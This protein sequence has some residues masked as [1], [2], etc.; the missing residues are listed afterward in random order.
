VLRRGA[1]SAGG[2]RR[3]V[4]RFDTLLDGG[5]ELDLRGPRGADLDL[6]LL[7]GHKRLRHSAGSGSRE[8][9]GYTVCGVRR[10]KARID[11]R[12]GGGS[13]RLVVTRP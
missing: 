11:A 12:R 5:L 6:T 9:I 2:D 1:I 3:D 4:I 10:F 13:Y 7:K 8:H